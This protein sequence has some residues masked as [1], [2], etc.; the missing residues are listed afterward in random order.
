MCRPSFFGYECDDSPTNENL[1]HKENNK[2][3]QLIFGTV[4]LFSSSLAIAYRDVFHVEGLDI[5]ILDLCRLSHSRYY[6]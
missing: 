6:T 2:L 1:K 3:R 4:I 5:D